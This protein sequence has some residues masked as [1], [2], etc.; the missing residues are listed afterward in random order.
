M[1]SD[2]ATLADAL[3][4]RNRIAAEIASVIG[5]PMTSGHAGEWI[6]AQIF[7]LKL[8]P[9]ATAKAIDGRFR[10][11]PLAGASLNV[12]WYLK[13]EGLLDLTP[14]VLPDYYL[15]LAGPRPSPATVSIRPWCIESVHLFAAHALVER[16][17][18]AGTRLGVATSIR[19]AEWQAAQIYPH[20]N[21]GLLPV[22][23]DQY[24]ALTLFLLDR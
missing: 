6:A 23:A 24:Q 15:V 2:L 11:G 4:R 1:I 18:A 14:D 20:A 9:G 13:Q 17:R 5:R 16:L 8:E 22:S 21:N 7:D 12:K 3:R 19:Q 10:S